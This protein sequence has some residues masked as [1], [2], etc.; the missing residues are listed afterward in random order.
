VRAINARRV[1]L[2]GLA[3]RCRAALR[4]FS[5]RA[6]AIGDAHA[7]AMGWTISQIPDPLGL[8]GR[9]YRDLRFGTP[10]GRLEQRPAASWASKD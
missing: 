4:E 9:S 2:N 1:G 10:S 7:R 8:A 5:D 3:D 6:H